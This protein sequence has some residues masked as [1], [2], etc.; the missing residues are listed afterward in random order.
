MLL[1]LFFW[2]SAGR[3]RWLLPLYPLAMA[4]TLVYTAEHFVIDVLLGWLYAVVVFV[5]GN[6][7]FDRYEQRGIEREPGPSAALASA[8]NNRV[9][10]Y[11]RRARSSDTAS[12]GSTAAR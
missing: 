7:L 1:V 9:P 3:W 11:F 12:P 10:Q 5:V 8:F 6:K 2:K 4:F